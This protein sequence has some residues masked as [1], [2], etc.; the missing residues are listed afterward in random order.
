MERSLYGGTNGWDRDG[1]LGTPTINEIRNRIMD[2]AGDN[3]L[4]D[5]VEFTSDQ[6]FQAIGHPIQEWESE[7]PPLGYHYTTKTFPWRERWAIA[8]IGYLYRYASAYYSRN[9]MKNSGGGVSIEDKNKEREYLTRSQIMLEE[10]R[11][12]MKQKKIQLN[13]EQFYGTI[14][15][16]Y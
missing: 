1:H 12:W 15:G 6:I 9:Y 7:L 3:L 16:S 8:T 4:L 5:D 10:W 2:Y 11:V 13:G 14:T